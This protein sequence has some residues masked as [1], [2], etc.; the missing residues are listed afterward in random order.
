MWGN[1]SPGWLKN[2][3]I[4]HGGYLKRKYIPLRMLFFKK[5][6][7]CIK[8][9]RD[10]WPMA[11]R[12]LQL[13]LSYSKGRVPAPLRKSRPSLDRNVLAS[14][15]KKKIPS[16]Q[17]ASRSL[18]NSWDGQ[19]EFCSLAWNRHP[20]NVSGMTDT[21]EEPFYHGQVPS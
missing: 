16:A 3:Y 5:K 13:K 7:S 18:R 1:H 14:A 9:L 10:L 4:L 6:I 19:I 21:T 15:A 20:K 12:C 11:S 8:E 2:Y 17:E